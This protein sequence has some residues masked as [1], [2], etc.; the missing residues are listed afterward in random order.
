MDQTHKPIIL[1]HTKNRNFSLATDKYHLTGC[2]SMNGNVPS[3][4]YLPYNLNFASHNQNP[5]AYQLTLTQIED[6]IAAIATMRANGTAQN[7]II[8][9]DGIPVGDESSKLEILDSLTIAEYK[10]ENILSIRQLSLNNVDI[11]K[12]EIAAQI[13]L[14]QSIQNFTRSIQLLT[15]KECEHLQSLL[16]VK[17]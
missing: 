11:L 5:G 9:I 6:I 16:E 3:Q 7:I 4:I 1:S 15:L 10:T 8:T 17:A 12:K 14:Q 2:S 13:R